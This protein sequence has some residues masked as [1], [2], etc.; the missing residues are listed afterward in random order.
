MKI[1]VSIILSMVFIVLFQTSSFAGCD[2]NDFIVT[3]NSAWVSSNYAL[4]EQTLT[5][6]VAEC[7]NDILA[8]GLLY[9]YYDNICV[10]YFKARDAAIDFIIATS[11]RM[12]SE[13]IHRRIPLELA[14]SLVEMPVPTNFPANQ[15]KTP[16]QMQ[17][18]HNW[19]VNAFPYVG[20]Y[21]E[22]IS[23]IEAVESGRVTD[24][25]FAPLNRDDLGE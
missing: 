9:E 2:T 22:L 18:L 20:I 10:D 4:L 14:I 3:V 21:Q 6:R 17:Y 16:A 13:V 5:N 24:D 15:S 25:Y 7:D 23:R 1:V 8:K 12:P 11:N 19:H